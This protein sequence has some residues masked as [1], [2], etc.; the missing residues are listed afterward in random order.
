MC[1]STPTKSHDT[2]IRSSMPSTACAVQPQKI[3]VYRKQ[4]LA[5]PAEQRYRL[6]PADPVDAAPKGSRPIASRSDVTY[7]DPALC[8]TS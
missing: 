1:K 6:L 3:T 2:G 5:D 4:Q 7:A 8:L